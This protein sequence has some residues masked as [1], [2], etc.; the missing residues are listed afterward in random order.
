M[1]KKPELSPKHWKAIKLIE[2]GRTMMKEI[3]EM[4]GFKKDYL[5][6]LYEGHDCTGGTG[7]LFHAEI[8]K[9]SKKSEKEIERLLKENKKLAMRVINDVLIRHAAL[10]YHTDDDAKLIS[11]LNNSLNKASPST[12]INA[13][14]YTYTRG[15]S[16]EDLMHEFNRLT[17]LVRQTPDRRGVPETRSRISGAISESSESGSGSGEE[18][19]APN[20]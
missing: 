17:S 4:C 20:L 8:E 3:A 1:S 2:E 14:S 18:P 12:Q 10:D 13:T 15:L 11:T 19:E 5:Y 9:I 7:Q 6:K 16:A